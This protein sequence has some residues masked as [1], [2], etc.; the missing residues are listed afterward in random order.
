MSQIST[1]CSLLNS[2][3]EADTTIF[4]YKLVPQVPANYILKYPIYDGTHH[5]K[6]TLFKNFNSQNNE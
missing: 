4:V 3:N 1:A 2:Q 6:L 5:H